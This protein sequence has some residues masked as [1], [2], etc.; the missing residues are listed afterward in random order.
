MTYTLKLADFQGPLDLLIHL[1]EKDKIDIYNIPIVS[2]TDQYIAYINAMQEYDLEVAS[3]FLLMAS[4]LL[5]LKSRMLLPK[6]KV[7]P[8]EEDADPRQMLVEMLVEYK[9]FKKRAELLRA[10]LDRASRSVARG[11]Q[12]ALPGIRRL[13]QYCLADLL[14]SLANLLPEE[15]DGQAVIARQEF[16]VQDKMAEILSALSDSPSLPFSQVLAHK[17]RGEFIAA[18]LAVLE[19]LR[20][21]KIHIDQQMAFAPMYIELPK[22]DTH[23]SEEAG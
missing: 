9:K 4:L 14:T 5:Q 18:F 13:H 22:E 15:E 1:I 23:E 3:E 2:I 16:N 17:D 11:P 12:P 8:D 21:H 20:L 6:E 19:L 10:E 7:D